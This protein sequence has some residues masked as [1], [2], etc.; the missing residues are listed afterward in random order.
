METPVMCSQFTTA[1]VQNL[2]GDPIHETNR[3][4]LYPTVR[5]LQ[6]NEFGIRSQTRIPVTCGGSTGP[7][8]RFPVARSRIER[9]LL[10]RVQRRFQTH[11][12][13]TRKST[14]ISRSDSGIRT[15][16]T[17]AVR[18]WALRTPFAHPP[19]TQGVGFNF[20]R[21]QRRR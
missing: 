20:P 11:K 5:R 21:K 17:A 10:G 12:L 4:S 19:R 14:R 2:F 8:R 6:Q 16:L 7:R 13:R 9:G 1:T 3:D 15:Q 18:P